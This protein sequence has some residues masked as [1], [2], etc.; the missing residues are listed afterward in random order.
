MDHHIFGWTSSK[1]FMTTSEE[2][3]NSTTQAVRTRGQYILRPDATIK[4][5]CLLTPRSMRTKR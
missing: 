2:S 3:S 5:S 1:D 4:M